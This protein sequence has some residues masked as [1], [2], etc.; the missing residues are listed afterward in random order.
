M[1]KMKIL[2]IC[3]YNRFRSKTAEVYFKKINKKIN[4]FSRGI[5][6]VNKPLDPAEKRRNIYLK[7]QFGFVLNA[8]SISVSV[9]DLMEADKV[10]IVADDVPRKLFNSVKWK[11]KVQI[12]NVSDEKADNKKNINK[13]VKIIINKVNDL[14]RK[15][16]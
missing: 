13:S 14:V 1:V 10:I 6:G 2:F 5:I 12:W 15:L 9:K 16:K 7:K 3:K 11:N 8:K 4:V